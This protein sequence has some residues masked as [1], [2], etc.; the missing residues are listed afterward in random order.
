MLLGLALLFVR[1]TA[2]AQGS[3]VIEGYVRD[4]H[5]KALADVTVVLKGGAGIQV[6]R[7][8]TDQE[9]HYLFFQI[10][11]GIYFITLEF[12]NTL[13]ESRRVEFAANETGAHRREDFTIENSIEP[14]APGS[15]NPLE[16]VFLQ[17]VPADAEQAYQKGMEHMQAGRRDEAVAAFELAAAK[18]PAYFNALN[19]LGL[20]YLRRGDV[21]RAGT[22]CQRAVT[23][24]KNSASARFGLGWAFYQAEKL[25]DAARE[26]SAAVKLNPRVAE[27]YWFLGMTEME[28]KRWAAAEQAFAS[29]RK[30][31]TRDDRPLLHL[32]LTS[33]YDSLGRT[34]AAITSLETYLKL[35]PEKDRTTKLRELLEQLKR[36][37]ERPA[38]GQ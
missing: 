7:V 4:R 22:V 29:F 15:T 27:S 30:L 24:N 2:N 20:E 21:A 28:R 36:K 17:Q 26:L 18:F 34:T 9:G 37:R 5:G 32:Y 6:D 31:Y 8:R 12:K 33:V 23:V 19:Q 16:P 13:E 38:S 35:A 10:G 1:A 11:P 14:S 3:S 25:N